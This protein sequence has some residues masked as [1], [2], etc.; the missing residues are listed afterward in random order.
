MLRSATFR[1]KGG[2]CDANIPTSVERIAAGIPSL[3]IYSEL[4]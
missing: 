1:H 3:E 4:A 2:V